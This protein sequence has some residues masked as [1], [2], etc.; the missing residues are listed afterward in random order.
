MGCWVRYMQTLYMKDSYMKEFE[1]T[2]KE[3]NNGK[4]IV[5]DKTAFYPKSGGQSKFGKPWERL[6]A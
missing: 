4:F 6:M 1:A 3:V 2:V 5:L